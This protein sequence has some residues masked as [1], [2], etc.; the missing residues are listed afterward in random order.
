MWLDRGEIEKVVAVLHAHERETAS[1]RARRA[2]PDDP[3]T[4]RDR[5]RQS[6]WSWLM[7][8]FD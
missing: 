6:T 2:E 4:D 7:Q 5:L 3:R 8:L 1:A